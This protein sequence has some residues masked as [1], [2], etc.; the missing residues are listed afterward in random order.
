[1]YFVL[2]SLQTVIISLNI[3]KQFIFVTVKSCVFFEVR[4]LFLNIIQTSFAYKGLKFL[5]YIGSLPRL[6]FLK[7]YQLTQNQQYSNGNS[8][9]PQVS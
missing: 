5:T 6:L 9:T 1:M 3:I 4:I 2:F 8:G 7:Q